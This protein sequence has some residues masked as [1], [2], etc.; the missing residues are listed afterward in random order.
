MAEEKKFND[1]DF[2]VDLR[3]VLVKMKDGL[4]KELEKKVDRIQN[5]HKEFEDVIVQAQQWHEQEKQ[6]Q[7]ERPQKIQEKIDKYSEA[8]KLAEMYGGK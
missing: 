1:K 5:I 4:G 8:E 7:E 2:L 6:R 3:S